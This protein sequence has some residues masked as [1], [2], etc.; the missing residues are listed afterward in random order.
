MKQLFEIN[1]T[2]KDGPIASTT[3]PLNQIINGK[4]TIKPLQRIQVDYIGYHLF[5]I[6][7]KTSHHYI[8][9]N[10]DNIDFEN[11]SI[12]FLTTKYLRQSCLLS[13][14]EPY[15]YTIR[16][17]NKEVET[18]VGINNHFSV[19]LAVFIKINE[20]AA[21]L[22]KASFL[23]KFSATKKLPKD[24]IYQKAFYLKFGLKDYDYQLIN[25]TNDLYKVPKK[26]PI[27]IISIT[28]SILFFALSA[29]LIIASFYLTTIVGLIAIVGIIS[30]LY[31]YGYRILG[32]FTIDYEQVDKETFFLKIHND[33]NWRYV[34]KMSVQYEI[35]E[36]MVYPDLEYEEALNA[37]IL[38]SSQI[39]TF[40]NLPNIVV[41]QKDFPKDIVGTMQVKEAHIYWIALV[42]V[43]TIWCIALPLKQK[44]VVRKKAKSLLP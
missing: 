21:I 43:Q 30:I 25:T 24:G 6:K 41:V 17:V 29:E 9:T 5:A 44:F 34:K 19:G 36:E 3:F 4:I 23:D 33:N 38:H 8:A 28:S 12:H 2:L 7:H 15:R 20:A 10:I 42:N 1:L 31:Y 11:D 18:Y 40:K 14:Y 22:K 26:T 13:E 37:E 35:R 39:Q 32:N 27:D 16:F